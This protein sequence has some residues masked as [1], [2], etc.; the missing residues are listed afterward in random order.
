MLLLFYTCRYFKNH[1]FFFNIYSSCSGK[2]GIL[3]SNGLKIAYLSGVDGETNQ[4]CNE[5]VFSPDDVQ[6]IRDS[7]VKNEDFKGV[8]LLL[9]YE[10]PADICKNETQNN[11]VSDACITFAL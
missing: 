3:K 10:W 8:D 6:F 4:T 1:I 2:R 5:T 11:L 9:T 7:C